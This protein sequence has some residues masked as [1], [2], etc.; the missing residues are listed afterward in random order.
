MNDTTDRNDPDRHDDDIAALLRT[1][2]GSSALTPPNRQRVLAEVLSEFDSAVARDETADGDAWSGD[3]I[4]TGT[5]VSLIEPAPDAATRHRRPRSWW[6]VAAA[7]A[8]VVGLVV[9]GGSR[10]LDED[11]APVAQS[12]PGVDDSLPAV[13]VELPE[14]GNAGPVDVRGVRYRTDDIANG[15]AFDGQPGLVLVEREDGLVVFE[16]PSFEG[17]SARLSIF[18][19]DPAT[20]TSTLEDA[21]A[22]GHLLIGDTQFVVDGETIVRR[23]L[24]VTG[25]GRLDLGCA[26]Q[27]ACIELTDSDGLFAPAVWAGAENF[28]IETDVDG[29]AVFVLAQSVRFGDPIANS[30]AALVAS[31]GVG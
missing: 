4:A 11:P 9:L 17:R 19:A 28:L 20:V 29:E 30:A 13:A 25:A 8:A 6:V 24:T 21:E 1:V 14:V 7:A 12:V 16:E 31:F 5:T 15:L 3:D 23:D 2:T 22:A 26:G 18:E 27:E 10:L